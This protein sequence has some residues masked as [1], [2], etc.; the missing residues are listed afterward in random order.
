V[1]LRYS[2]D[3]RLKAQATSE[4]AT[5]ALGDVESGR[6]L[7]RD[8]EMYL[9][10]NAPQVLEGLRQRE[11]QVASGFPPRTVWAQW[12]KVADVFESGDLEAIR[13]LNLEQYRASLSEQDYRAF[14]N[15]RR[16]L[17]QGAAMRENKPMTTRQ[18][19]TRV[20]QILQGAGL[21]NGNIGSV[22]DVDKY[23]ADN[24]VFTRT[25]EEIITRLDAEA[26]KKELPLTGPEMEAVIRSVTDDL[27]LRT[28]GRNRAVPRAALQEGQDYREL[29]P[30]ERTRYAPPAPAR[31]PAVQR[32]AQLKAQGLDNAAIYAKMTEEGYTDAD[33]S[34]RP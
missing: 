7:S 13:D 33:Y 9:T 23:P 21:M 24:A 16:R 12:E 31:L 1:Q 30:E 29:T 20:L 27:V 10:E 32:A 19:E 5:R 25:R 4:V 15:E 6:G 26:A 2:E 8:D 17:L 11:M 34:Q 18:T 14:Q 3:R 22:A 28:S